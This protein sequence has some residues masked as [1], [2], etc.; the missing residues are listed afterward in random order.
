MVF[1]STIIDIYLGGLSAYTRKSI[2]NS[3]LEMDV[4]VLRFQIFSLYA[5]SSNRERLG[6]EIIKIILNLPFKKGNTFASFF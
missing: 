4:E 1:K 6:A 2:F 3:I 5:V